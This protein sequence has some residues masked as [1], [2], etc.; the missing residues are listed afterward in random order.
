MYDFPS[1]SISF[2]FFVFRFFRIPSQIVLVHLFLFIF[3][4]FF[5]F[6]IGV[7]VFA[8]QFADCCVC[9]QLEKHNRAILF[10]LFAWQIFLPGTENRLPES[11]S[12]V[13]GTVAEKNQRAIEAQPAT[14][15]SKDSLSELEF[16]HGWRDRRLGGWAAGRPGFGFYPG[17]ALGLFVIISISVGQFT[18]TSRQ[19]QQPG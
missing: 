11:G 4:F 1:Y 16:F 10:Q 7:C 8:F 3:F 17:L 6:C 14:K 19:R 13:Q 9:A 18:F 2:F 15:L 12:R 5:F